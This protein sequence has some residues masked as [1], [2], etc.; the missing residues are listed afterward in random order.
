ML[1]AAYYGADL[2]LLMRVVVSY[3]S[4]MHSHPT[5]LLLHVACPQFDQAGGSNLSLDQVFGVA[6]KVALVTGAAAATAAAARTPAPLIDS[7]K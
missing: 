6:G 5:K 1:N 2:T 3:D 7:V 4:H